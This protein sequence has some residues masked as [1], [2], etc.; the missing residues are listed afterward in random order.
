M[1]NSR[2]NTVLALLVA[3][4]LGS[5]TAATGNGT[6]DGAPPS[7]E[8]VCDDANLE[9]A[10]FGLC[11]AFCEAGDCPERPNKASCRS[12]RRNFTRFTGLE[13]FPCEQPSFCDLNPCHPDCMICG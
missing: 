6:P 13:L 2:L 3:M 7:Q 1:R 5:A 8:M 9:R 11:I 4:T 12:L 10:A